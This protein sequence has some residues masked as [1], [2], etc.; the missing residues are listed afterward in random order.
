MQGVRSLPPHPSFR[1]LA[2][3]QTDNSLSRSWAFVDFHL[4]AQATRALL[5]LHNHQL[6][7]RKLNVEYASAEA[8]RRGQLGSR[9]VSKAHGRQRREAPAEGAD[10]G[11]GD[12]AG[13][14]GGAGRKRAEREWDDGDVRSFAA[15][16]VADAAANGNGRPERQRRE[17]MPR[18]G[19]GAERRGREPQPLP[20]GKRAKPGAALAMAQRASEAIVP[21]QGK[22]VTF[23]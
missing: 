14:G 13:G 10:E 11:Y 1:R 19:D 18:G 3:S 15:E 6:N 23:D 4:A 22:K 17:K 5:N 12:R 9:A 2:R 16:A 8:V 20:G 21:G 7:G